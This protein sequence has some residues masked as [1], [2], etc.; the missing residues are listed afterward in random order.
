MMS[1]RLRKATT[2][3]LMAEAAQC[4]ERVEALDWNARWKRPPL[5]WLRSTVQRRRDSYEERVFVELK[6][7]YG[8]LANRL[9]VS[10][11]RPRPKEETCEDFVGL[12]WVGFR[13]RL[14]EPGPD[15]GQAGSV[16]LWESALEAA[17]DIG[18]ANPSALMDPLKPAFMLRQFVDAIPDRAERDILRVLFFDAALAQP[19]GAE[20]LRTIEQAYLGLHAVVLRYRSELDEMTDGVIP[21]SQFDGLQGDSAIVEQYDAWLVTR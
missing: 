12:M 4:R 17:R 1:S 15:V 13:E 14:P 6:Q 5:K 9:V 7:R 19:Q 21:P 20:A 3:T 2:W 16:L 18:A 8:G 10:L 11:G